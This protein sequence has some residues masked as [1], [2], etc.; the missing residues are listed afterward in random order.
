MTVTDDP[1]AAG[2]Y[3][4]SDDLERISKLMALV[5]Y[6][7]FSSGDSSEEWTKWRTKGQEWLTAE[8]DEFPLQGLSDVYEELLNEVYL[9]PLGYEAGTDFIV[10]EDDD[11][12]EFTGFT[13]GANG[14]LEED[15]N[16]V[17]IP[18]GNSEKKDFVKVTEDPPLVC[19]FCSVAEADRFVP[20][21]GVHFCRACYWSNCDVTRPTDHTAE[22]PH[23]IT[24][25]RSTH[26]GDLVRRPHRP[27][28]SQG[29]LPDAPDPQDDV[30]E[31]DTLSWAGFGSGDGSAPA[32]PSPALSGC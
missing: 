16:V 12:E 4:M 7:Y 32:E 13:V 15:H 11:D 22:E 5:A 8:E 9:F 20:H 28:D 25:R 18:A 26:G 14:V 31:P 21:L 6:K 23:A 24:N 10:E 19:D 17:T 27:D 3:D 1:V 30:R 2:T 29:P